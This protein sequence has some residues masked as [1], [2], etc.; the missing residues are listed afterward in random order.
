[1][2]KITKKSSTKA[3]IAAN[4]AKSSLK[5]VT[6]VEDVEWDANLQRDA[7]RWEENDARNYAELASF[8]WC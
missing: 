6:R 4:R 2:A 7:A 1:M 5:T 3:Q 8:D